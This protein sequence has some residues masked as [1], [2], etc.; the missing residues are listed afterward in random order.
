[1]VFK[2][3][4]NSKSIYLVDAIIACE[5]LDVSRRVFDNALGDTMIEVVGSKEEMKI[6]KEIYAMV[7][8]N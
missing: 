5:H 3:Y 4:Y 6:F 2:T 1:M 8:G 7:G